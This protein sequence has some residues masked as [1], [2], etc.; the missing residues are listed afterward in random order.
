MDAYPELYVATVDGVHCRIWEP[1]KLPSSR[2]YSKKFNKAALTYEVGVAIHHNK[3][4]W[5]NGP[6]PAGENDKK[7]FDKPQG[8]ASKLRAHQKVIGDEGYRGS[9]EKASTRNRAFDSREV[10]SFKN[11]ALARHETVNSRLKAFAIINQPFRTTGQRRL[12][13]HQAAMEA[14]CVIVQYELENKSPL[15]A[16]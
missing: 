1:R 16:V 9:P 7:V 4:V 2:W 3:I 5:I 10:K 12:P 8:L 6:F 13:R 14:A 15:F 11:R